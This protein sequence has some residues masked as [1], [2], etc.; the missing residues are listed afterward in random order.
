M[1]NETL[2]NNFYTIGVKFPGDYEET[3]HGKMYTYKVP[4]DIE[5]EIGDYAV[6]RVEGKNPEI[7]IVKVFEIALGDT[8]DP[9]APFK[10]KWVIQKV[11][12]DKYMER[13]EN[14]RKLNELV[15]ALKNRK[16]KQSVLDEIST[17][18]TPEELAQIK[19]LSGLA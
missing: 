10:Y 17:V 18:A 19:Q 2:Q 11:E 15:A 8:T 14:D 5:F 4:N 3:Y 7:K 6:V 16:L 13:L 12:L 1:S 9:N